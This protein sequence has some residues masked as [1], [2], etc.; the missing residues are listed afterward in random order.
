MMTYGDGTLVVNFDR[1]RET[2]GHIQTAVSALQSQLHRLEADAAPLVA[3]WTGTA[4]E[5]YQERQAV[6]RQA[7]DDL[8]A[9]LSAIRRA[10]DESVADYE[11]TERRNT[12]LFR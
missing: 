1:L 11:Y 5:A 10:L 6:W 12:S 2:S 9:M 3:T 7:S 8:T 4:R